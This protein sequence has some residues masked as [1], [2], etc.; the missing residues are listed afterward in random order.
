L[1]E[2]PAKKTLLGPGNCFAFV[3]DNA[4][5]EYTQHT[6]VCTLLLKTVPRNLSIIPSQ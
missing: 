4:L 2:Q 1:V 5:D 6:A 3:V